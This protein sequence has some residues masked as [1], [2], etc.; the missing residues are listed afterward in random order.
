MPVRWTD[1][2][3]TNAP[4]TSGAPGKEE[5]LAVQMVRPRLPPI[6]QALV[7]AWATPI[8]S[9]RWRG[10]PVGG[11]A[12]R[13][14]A[15]PH[16][17]AGPVCRRSSAVTWRPSPNGAALITGPG[18]EPVG[19]ISGWYSAAFK[20]GLWG[21]V[22]WVA[23]KRAHQGRGLAKAGL[24]YTLHR[25]AERHDR[26]FLGTHTRAVGAHQALPG[27]WVRARPGSRGARQHGRH[28]GPGS[29]IR[30]STPWRNEA[31][32]TSRPAGGGGG[33]S[34]LGLSLSTHPPNR[35]PSTPLAHRPEP[36]DVDRD[37]WPS[38]PW[39]HWWPARSTPWPGAGRSSH[40]PRSRAW[41]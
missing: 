12:A 7:P 38:S 37:S 8:R 35:L 19:T 3:S 29:G 34:D 33:D 6:Q 15:L 27:L 20:G 18:G 1:D 31:R 36:V 4:S 25:L 10:C 5:L 11:R 23:V 13:R 28:W 32:L 22:H 39:P 14:R 30:G 24:T 40:F 9:M 41:G 2:R 17:R 21:Q 26:A 16:H